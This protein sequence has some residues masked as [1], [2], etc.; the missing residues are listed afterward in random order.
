MNKLKFLSII[1]VILLCFT[2]CGGKTIIASGEYQFLDGA[3]IPNSYSVTENPEGG[4][5]IYQGET[6]VG[7]IVLLDLPELSEDDPY[8]LSD[9]LIAA[10]KEVAKQHCPAEYDY[11]GDN[12]YKDLMLDVGLASAD[13]NSYRHCIIETTSGYCDIWF[14]LAQIETEA[15]ANFIEQLFG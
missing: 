10:A 7:G 14:D 9:Y 8:H 5:L 13:G 2:A 1:L 11:I 15:T 3:S 6:L 12:A 4:Y